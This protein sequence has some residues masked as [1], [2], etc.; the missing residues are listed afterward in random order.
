[1]VVTTYGDSRFAGAPCDLFEF[2]Y[3]DNPGDVFRYTNEGRDVP[4]NGETWEQESI[5]HTVIQIAGRGKRQELTIEVPKSSGIGDYYMG[6]IPE[7]TVHLKIYEGYVTRDEDS[8][9]LQEDAGFELVWTGTIRDFNSKDNAPEVTF[10][11]ATLESAIRRPGLRRRY[12]RTCTHPILFGGRCGASKAAATYATTVDSI[13][14]RI[15]TLPTGWNGSHNVSRFVG[16]VVEYTGTYGVTSRKI[17][18]A[19]ATTV[20]LETAPAGLSATD[21]IDVILGCRRTENFCDTVHGAILD[22]GGQKEIPKENPVRK[23]NHG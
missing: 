20:T 3:G 11:C 14:G 2:T 7:R 5:T 16:G 8:G 13:S 18:D 19:D 22:F 1:M 12:Q 17:L 23:N 4:W 21:D 9:V 15:V 6:G 10:S